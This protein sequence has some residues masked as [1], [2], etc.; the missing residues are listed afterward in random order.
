MYR[1]LFSALLACPF[2]F[3]LL[4][5]DGSPQ[6]SPRAKAIGDSIAAEG[7]NPVLTNY[8][9]LKATH[10]FLKRHLSQAD[11]LQLTDH[12][13]VGV[14][15][16]A[17]WS[18]S[19]EKNLDLFPVLV[20]HMNDTTRVLT[21]HVCSNRNPYFGDVLT[22]I[23]LYPKDYS[24]PR[25]LNELQ[26]W[27]L[28]SLHLYSNLPL[29]ARSE[30]IGRLAASTASAQT[31]PNLYLRFR[32][33]VL[34]QHD[35][36]AL[37]ALA[38]YRRAED[39]P[40]ILNNWATSKDNEKGNLFVYN[41]VLAFP[42]PAFRERLAQDLAVRLRDSF[43][44]DSDAP[45]LYSTI[46]QYYDEWS[47]NTLRTVITTPRQSLAL[48]P[49]HL[50]GL[51]SVLS[52]SIDVL[53]EPLLWELW[54]KE[55]RISGMALP[56]LVKRDSE[57]AYRLARKAAEDLESLYKKDLTLDGPPYLIDEIN[58]KG[59]V[60]TDV[61]TQILDM[62]LKREPQAAYAIIRRGLTNSGWEISG[63][64]ISEAVKIGDRSFVDP[65]LV[66]L[67]RAEDP[68]AFIPLLRALISYKDPAVKKKA[69]AIV[70]SVQMQDDV[71]NG[72]DYPDVAEA[73]FGVE[74]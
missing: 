67:R 61:F 1:L 47:V 68:D 28:D 4:P 33:L 39:I 38:K 40:L 5:G 43:M 46:M 2:V 58:I 36:V 66:H 14:R 19:E 74:R 7:I 35:F 69:A 12:P 60:Y 15:Y 8:V 48:R 50:K 10:D 45:L 55:G 3:L 72:G 29:Q 42:D 51:Q 18:L 57:R 22:Q 20:K 70:R 23:Y 44:V 41:A 37:W 32:Q 65:M 71:V 59:G 53:Y 56:F 25:K 49:Y 16:F 30:A 34:E 13:N 26:Q 63:L 64:F 27:Q 73:L 21:C 17:F 6:P 9:D 11:R 54:E 31:R 62:V 52:Q 24:K